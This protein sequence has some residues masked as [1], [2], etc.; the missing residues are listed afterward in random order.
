MVRV[1]PPA[2]LMLGCASRGMK[3]YEEEYQPPTLIQ[4]APWSSGARAKLTFSAAAFGNSSLLKGSYQNRC[5]P[6]ISPNQ[7]IAF[8][9]DELCKGKGLK[10]Q[11]S[12]LP[13]D[14]FANPA[15]KPSVMKAARLLRDSWAQSTRC[16]FGQEFDA[17]PFGAR[18]TLTSG[19]RNGRPNWILASLVQV[20]LLLLH[21]H[22]R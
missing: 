7:I 1:F 21:Q 17:S 6:F 19:H 18:A 16:C 22:S 9:I 5:R 15:G 10:S 2:Q 14:A 8:A 20:R 3:E 4:T 11:V 12:E 13:G